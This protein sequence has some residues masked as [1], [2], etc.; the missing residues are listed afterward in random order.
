MNIS[1][2][3]KAE[4]SAVIIKDATTMVFQD[5]YHW[6]AWLGQR[7]ANIAA[8]VRGCKFFDITDKWGMPNEM[9]RRHMLEVAAI[10]MA[11]DPRYEIL[12]DTMKYMNAPITRMESSD[13]AAELEGKITAL[14]VVGLGG[15]ISRKEDPVYYRQFPGNV[16]GAA[17]QSNVIEKYKK[18]EQRFGNVTFQTPLAGFSVAYDYSNIEEH[19]N[20]DNQGKYHG[21]TF[22][23]GGLDEKAGFSHVADGG[24]GG[25]VT[26]WVKDFLEPLAD[27]AKHLSSEVRELFQSVTE[28]SR[29]RYFE[30]I[31]GSLGLCNTEFPLQMFPTRHRAV[32][33][34]AGNLFPSH[35]RSRHF[36]PFSG[37]SR[38]R[39]QSGYGTR[40]GSGRGTGA[41]FLHDEGS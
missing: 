13:L 18:G 8:M 4:L 27:K 21:L 39:T 31:S 40:M 26:K 34:S 36:G 38:L 5:V 30:E 12:K 28:C 10:S 22:S 7:W 14:G 37:I 35:R 25:K 6:A 19:A 33:A 17:G 2:L 24:G 20:I 15:M 9:Q 41:R 32:S 23:L 16:R 3:L 1:E 29:L 11:N